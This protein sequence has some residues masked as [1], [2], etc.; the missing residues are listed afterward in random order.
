MLKTPNCHQGKM[1]SIHR[2]SIK[3]HGKIIRDVPSLQIQLM[4]HTNRQCYVRGVVHN[5][6]YTR[7]LLLETRKLPQPVSTR[8]VLSRLLSSCLVCVLSVEAFLLLLL[9][10]DLERIK[11]SMAWGE[12]VNGIETQVASS[13]RGKDGSSRSVS[14]IA[15]WVNNRDLAFRI[16]FDG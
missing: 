10:I 9:F 5:H 11:S 3:V 14:C 7:A 6:G 13:E 2:T 4:L 15:T 16:L 8:R 1:D 12:R